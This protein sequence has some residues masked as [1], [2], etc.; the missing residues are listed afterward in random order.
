MEMPEEAPA[1]LSILETTRDADCLA[2]LLEQLEN[3]QVPYVVEAG[4]AISLL[5]DDSAPEIS[6]PDPWQA[7]LWIPGSFGA[8]AAEVIANAPA[9][10][11]M[12]EPEEVEA[13][14]PED[15]KNPVQPR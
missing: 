6:A 14:D 13:L 10:A 2:I 9:P 3:A 8:R 5:D 12:A 15:L 7:R 1:R 4:T 11:P